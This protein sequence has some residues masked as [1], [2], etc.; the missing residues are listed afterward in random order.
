MEV[1]PEAVFPPLPPLRGKASESGRRRHP[2]GN[3]YKGSK[4]QDLEVG[5]LEWLISLSYL[6]IS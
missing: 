1:Q 4:N 5:R 3:P 6:K 2:A